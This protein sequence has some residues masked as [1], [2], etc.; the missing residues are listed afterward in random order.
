MIDIRCKRA[1]FLGIKDA[2][3]NFSVF[4]LTKAMQYLCKKEAIVEHINAQIKIPVTQ[5]YRQYPRN[6]ID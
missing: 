2:L 3:Y 5:N 4:F 6:M 1:I